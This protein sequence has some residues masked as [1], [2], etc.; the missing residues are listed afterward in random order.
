MEA[1]HIQ[2][3]VSAKLPLLKMNEFEMWRLRVEQY[4]QVQDYA[5]WEIIEDGNSFKPQVTSS[6]VNNE[7]VTTIQTSPSTAEENIQKRNDL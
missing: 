7:L 4:F 6:T 2:T 5:L 1:E 3:N